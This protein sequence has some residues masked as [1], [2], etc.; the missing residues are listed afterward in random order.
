MNNCGLSEPLVIYIVERNNLKKIQKLPFIILTG[1]IGKI[2][3]LEECAH[4]L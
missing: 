3:I 2:I 4:E 1:D